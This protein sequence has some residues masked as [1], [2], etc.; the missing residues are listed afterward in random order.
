MKSWKRFHL[1]DPDK[2]EA[3]PLFDKIFHG[4]ETMKEFGIAVSLYFS[5]LRWFQTILLVLIIL[6]GYLTYQTLEG[7]CVRANCNAH[8]RIP[9]IQTN[10][11][12]PK[13]TLIISTRAAYDEDN[14]TSEARMSIFISLSSISFRDSPDGT[15]EAYH[16]TLCGQVVCSML[17]VMAA[18]VYTKHNVAEINDGIISSADFA[19]EITNLPRKFLTGDPNLQA[20]DSP[21]RQG[22]SR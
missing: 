17:G 6:S 13:L 9:T 8:L 1:D 15:P 4:G 22:R 10:H 3:Y 2:C 14:F 21:T 12:N 19:V 16:W 5:L 11:L 18:R 20:L 7:K